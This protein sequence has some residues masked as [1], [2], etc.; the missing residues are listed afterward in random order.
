[1]PYQIRAAAPTNIAMATAPAASRLE[2]L[3]DA[4]PVAGMT[5]PVVVATASVDCVKLLTI[6][7]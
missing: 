3:K 7:V 5:E 1:M 2:E 4:P 6:L